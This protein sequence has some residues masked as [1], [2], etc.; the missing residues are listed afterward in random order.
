MVFD[1]NRSVLQPLNS[2]EQQSH[3]QQ[4]QLDFASNEVP[5]KQERKSPDDQ[6]SEANL[7]RKLTGDHRMTA[8]AFDKPEEK[9]NQSPS[10]LND[11]VDNLLN[12]ECIGYEE[13]MELCI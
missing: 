9:E 6:R 5:I 4:P 13:D 12:E 10:A 3:Q 8:I 11:E 2:G 1:V 7:T